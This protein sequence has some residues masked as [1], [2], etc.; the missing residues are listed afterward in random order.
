GGFVVS[1][2]PRCLVVLLL[3]TSSS[4]LWAQPAGSVTGRIVWGGKEI[5]ERKPLS[6]QGQDKD[7]CLAKGPVLDEEYVVNAKNKGLQWT[8][9]FLA[10][11]SKDVKMRVHPSVGKIPED[12]RHVLIEHV[13]CRYEPHALAMREGQ[14][15]RVRNR[16]KIPHNFKWT[17]R[18]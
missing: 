8:F 5:P 18:P 6:I 4:R 17:G 16:S 1:S 11:R 3:L 15:L 7:S 14:I 13:Q 12:K 10:P 2:A 9:V